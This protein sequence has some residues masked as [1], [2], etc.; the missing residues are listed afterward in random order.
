MKRGSPP[1]LLQ[2]IQAQLWP[3]P[4]AEVNSDS[5][6]LSTNSDRYVGVTLTDR[7]PDSS[8]NLGRQDLQTLELGR[9][10]LSDDQI[11]LPLWE[12]P[13]SSTQ[14]QDLEWPKAWPTPNAIAK[15]M[16]DA[17]GAGNPFRG[18]EMRYAILN[19]N[20]VD[21]LMGLPIGWSGCEPLATESFQSWQRAHSCLLR[22]VP[23]CQ[24]ELSTR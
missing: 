12:T 18:T 6:D 1:G 21:W 7:M 2:Q 22:D 11:S 9:T 4:I 15:V 3:T 23:D 5:E 10:F 8:L 19:P 13:E 17:G 20:F 16:G 14:D 24:A